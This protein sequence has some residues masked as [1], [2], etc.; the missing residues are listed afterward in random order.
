M[1][2]RCKITAALFTASMF[3]VALVMSTPWHKLL[4]IAARVSAHHLQQCS[5]CTRECCCAEKLAW[6]LS[7]Y[8]HDRSSMF[9]DVHLNVCESC[10][11]ML[12]TG[13]YNSNSVQPVVS[14]E[15]PVFYR[16]R[17]SGCNLMRP[18][19]QPVNNL[20][21]STLWS[22]PRVA[23]T[24]LCG[25][26]S[27]NA[28]DAISCSAGLYSALAYAGAQASKNCSTSTPLSCAALTNI[29]AR[30]HKYTTCSKKT[31]APTV[32]SAF[33]SMRRN[34]R[35]VSCQSCIV[36]DEHLLSTD[37]F[38][39]SQFRTQFT[40]ELPYVLIQ[41][42]IFSVLVRVYITHKSRS[43]KSKINGAML[44]SNDTAC[45]T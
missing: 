6:Y 42:V 23:L 38:N 9:H 27:G 21:T 34:T 24:M 18:I 16:E 33:D 7:A 35:G 36:R 10:F 32:S 13:M 28:C 25:C 11:S 37:E 20:R 5:G 22:N 29:H 31:N 43:T 26:I 15:R 4:R 44:C 45:F 17:A 1:W 30:A 41:S 8:S 3:L 40:I 12:P 2:Q 39:Q 14:I 19:G